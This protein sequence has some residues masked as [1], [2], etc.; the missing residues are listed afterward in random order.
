MNTPL[1]SFNGYSKDVGRDNLS[2]NQ[3][4]ISFRWAHISDDYISN[5]AGF[6]QVWDY[7]EF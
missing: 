2:Q 4:Q 1:I 6:G 5:K 3:L 7:S